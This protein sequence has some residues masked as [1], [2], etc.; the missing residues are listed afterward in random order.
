MGKTDN[1]QIRLALVIMGI[2][3]AGTEIL[4]E[5]ISEGA[6]NISSIRF[7][8]AAAIVGIYYVFALQISTS[9]KNFK[10]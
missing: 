2:L 3:I 5:Y 7:W 10:K 6:E 8:F 1:K 4:T 9:T